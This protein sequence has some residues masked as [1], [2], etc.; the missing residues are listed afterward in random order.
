[1]G[2][3]FPGTPY[4]DVFQN[5]GCV[6]AIIRA[7]MLSTPRRIGAEQPGNYNLPARVNCVFYRCVIAQRAIPDPP[8]ARHAS[9]QERGRADESD[10]AR[11]AFEEADLRSALKEGGQ[12]LGAFIVARSEEEFVISLRCNWILGW[13]LR[14][15]RSWSGLSGDR[16]FKNLQSAWH[17][18]RKFNFLGCVTV[19]PAGD[20]EHRQFVGMSPCDLGELADEVTAV[21]NADRSAP[22]CAAR[23]RSQTK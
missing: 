4:R 21:R 5:H 10:R 23:R 17:F 13:G 2:P 7:H 16:S 6:T 20:P 8:C 22:R 14:T 19:Y 18:V 3:P 1:M 9:R 12:V 11:N 15:I